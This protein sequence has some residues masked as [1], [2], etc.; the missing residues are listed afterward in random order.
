M[1]GELPN[2]VVFP[3]CRGSPTRAASSKSKDQ[4]QAEGGD[5]DMRNSKWLHLAAVLAVLAAIVPAAYAQEGN[6][7]IVPA[8]ESIW[9]GVGA[10]QSNVLV[11]PGFD[12]IHGAEIAAIVKNAQG[13]IMG[14]EVALDVQDTRCDPADSTNVANLFAS[15]PQIVAVMGHMCSGDAA[16]AIPIYYAARIP[17]V[18]GSATSPAVD[19]AA[20]GTDVFNRTALRDIAQGQVDAEYMYNVLGLRRI[21]GMHDNDTYGLTLAEIVRDNFIALGGEVVAFEGIN[22]DDTDYRATLTLIAAE[23]PELIFFGGYDDQ[24]I[25]IVDQK[26]E[27]GMQDVIF[28]SDDGMYTQAFIA[29]AG[30][31]AEGQYASFALDD[32]TTA[33]ANMLFDTLYFEV[34][35]V[36][37]DSMG[38]FHAHAYDATA[39]I[40]DA[41][42]RVAV[43]NED[44]SLTIDREELIQAVR[45]TEGLPGLTGT[46]GCIVESDIGECTPSFIGVYQVQEGAWV[47]VYP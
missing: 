46:L 42:E 45:A 5:K 22:R 14:H 39:I 29:G 9:I 44:G 28:F 18:S 37:P 30:E 11:E 10:D 16:A 32:P 7:V 2:C 17:M 34:F 20:P 4:A 8:G 21:A 25:L 6:V 24:G 33:L 12:I 36:M 15:N 31:D 23:E 41:I 19:E 26:N 47:Q 3:L 40:L 43:E 27:L 35:G 13:G 38:P 1:P